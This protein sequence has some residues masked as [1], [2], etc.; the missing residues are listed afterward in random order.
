MPSKTKDPNVKTLR[1]TTDLKYWSLFHRLTKYF[2]GKTTTVS[3]EQMLDKLKDLYS[4]SD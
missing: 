1:F 2:P 3:F 4:V